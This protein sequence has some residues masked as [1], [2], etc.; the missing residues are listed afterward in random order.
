MVGGLSSAAG[1]LD[2]MTITK[3]AKDFENL[4][5]IPS[6]GSYFPSECVAAIDADRIF[7][8]G[9]RRCVAGR[10]GKVGSFMYTKR[11]D[12]WVEMPEMPTGKTS[13]ACG[14]AMDGN[15]HAEVVVIGGSWRHSGSWEHG[16]EIFNVD[17]E[18]WRNGK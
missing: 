4:A 11:N 2:E 9:L 13:M 15:G 17:E 16:V 12:E 18:I 5:P 3:N 8:T 14:V 10:C 6:D 1:A 7:S